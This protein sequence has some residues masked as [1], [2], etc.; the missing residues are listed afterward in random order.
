[1]TD[2]ILI[3]TDLDRTLI[4]NGTQPESPRARPLFHAICN[5]P[6]VTLAYVSGRDL[7]LQLDAIR[8][9]DLPMPD[10]AIGDVGT[11][12]YRLMNGGYEP[13]EAWDQE[14]AA[15]W[16]GRTSHDIAALLEETGPFQLQEPERQNTWKLSYHA[17]AR[18]VPDDTMQRIQAILDDHGLDAALIWSIDETRDLGLLDII[19]ARATKLHAIEFLIEQQGID[20]LRTVFA[21]DSGNDL[22][23]LGSSIP[24]VLV[25]NAEA[26]VR[27]EALRLAEANGHPDRLWCARG[28][29]GDMNGNYA[30]GILEGLIHFLPETESWLKQ[31]P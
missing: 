28:G 23:V 18:P 10:F 15:D 19:P 9:Y 17:P 1:M 6:E 8:D 12:I 16:H 29:H 13:W 22:P 27:R 11:S 26:S 5:R 20:F 14:I 31:L 30:A 4:P 21:G 25:A 7:G 3:C 24:S 2:R